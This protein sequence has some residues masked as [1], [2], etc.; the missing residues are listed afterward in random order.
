MNKVTEFSVLKC[1]YDIEHFHVEESEKPDYIL[2]NRCRPDLSKFGVEI[3][4]LFANDSH[5]RI[6]NTLG[7]FDDIIDKGKYIHKDDVANLPC[8]E[9]TLISPDKIEYKVMGIIE[10][11]L[12]HAELLKLAHTIEKKSLAYDM[13]SKTCAY[14]NLVIKD[15]V[16]SVNYLVNYKRV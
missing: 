6:S 5:A 2:N 15:K 1:V 10:Y 16:A 8:R 13:Y 11:P 4:E 7:Y 9:I 12:P 3:T 14:H